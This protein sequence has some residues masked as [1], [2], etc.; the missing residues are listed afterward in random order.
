MQAAGGCARSQP[1]VGGTWIDQVV[2]GPDGAEVSAAD[3]PTVLIYNVSF[4]GDLERHEAALRQI[5]G[6][7]LCVSEAPVA[8]RA[9]AEVRAAAKAELGSD[10]MTF[11][12]TDEVTGHVDIG[13]LVDDGLQ[14]QMDERFG[15]GVVRLHPTL[16]PVHR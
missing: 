5:W 14:E 4:T 7:K 8:A 11:S 10:Q 2:E 9:L 13:V 6:G 15:E 16:Q 12:A 3:D 1:D